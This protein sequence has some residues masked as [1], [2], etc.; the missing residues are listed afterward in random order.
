MSIGSV[1]ISAISKRVVN[2][3]C[4]PECGAGMTEVDRCNE[5]ESLFVWYQC[6]KKNC[7]GQWLQKNPQD[8]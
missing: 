3:R 5:N 2:E 4:C 1:S 6:S 8:L 7:D